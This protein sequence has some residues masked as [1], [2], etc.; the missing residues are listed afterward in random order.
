MRDAGSLDELLREANGHPVGGWDFVWL[1]NR[2]IDHPLP[3]NYEAMLIAFTRNSPDLL[4]LGTGGGEFLA[5]LGHRPPRTVATEAW[6]PNVEIARQ[7]LRPLG[8]EV[9]EVESA[10]ENA[11]QD[12]AAALARL[13]F[14]DDSFALVASRHESY[15]PSEVARIL[16]PEGVFLTQQVGGDY[17]EF[18]EALGLPAPHA[19]GWNLKLAISQLDAAGLEVRDSGEGSAATTFADIG[20]FAWYLRAIPWVVDGFSI[21]T[22]RAQLELLH[23]RVIGEGPVTIRMPAFWVEAASRKPLRQVRPRPAEFSSLSTMT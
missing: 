11:E 19:S 20:A 22:H 14:A 12:G 2:L 1:G 18:Y 6:P 21:E 23:R 3:W 9:V 15:V 4:D 17:R 7:R 8:V 13:P 5:E 16:R 10:G